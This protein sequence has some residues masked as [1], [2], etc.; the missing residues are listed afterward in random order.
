VTIRAAQ[1]ADTS[2][3]LLK[4]KL[5]RSAARKCHQEQDAIYVFLPI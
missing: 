5:R 1:H 2:L 3:D 4:H